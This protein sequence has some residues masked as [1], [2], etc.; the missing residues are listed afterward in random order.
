MY[1]YKAYLCL[2]KPV[3]GR[4]NSPGLTDRLSLTNKVKQLQI[5]YVGQAIF[6]RET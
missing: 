5:L 3:P 2:N 6:W 4:F 1:P